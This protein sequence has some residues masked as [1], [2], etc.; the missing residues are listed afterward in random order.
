MASSKLFPM[1]KKRGLWW[2]YRKRVP[3]HLRGLFGGRREI[4][5]SLKT[6]DEGEA[7][8]RVL[9]IAHETE[10]ALQRAREKHRALV[11][12]P[13]AMAREWR[14][15]ILRV[16]QQDRLNRPRTE[17]SLEAEIDALESAVVDHREALQRGDTRPVL[18]VLRDVLERHKVTLTPAVERQL[19]HALLRERADALEI[20]LQRALGQ[21]RDEPVAPVSPLVSQVMESW[22]RERKPPSKT[23][24]EVR[25]IFG[26]FLA[27]CGGDQGIS[28]ITKDHVRAFRT[29]LLAGDAKT[30]KGTGA[31]APATIRKHLNLLGTVFR[32][33]VRTGLLDV[34]PVAGMA[35]VA[36]SKMQ[37]ASGKRQPFSLEAVRAFLSSPLYTGSVS[38]ARRAVPGP[39]IYKDAIWWTGLILFYSG[40]R[41]EE[42]GGLRG[43]DV[44]ER[45]G[46]MGFS[47]EVGEDRSLKTATAAR[48]VPLHPALVSAGLVDLAR[49]RGDGWLFPELK[50][51]RHG[52]RT[53]AVSKAFGRYLRA[54]KLDN[55]GKVVMHSARHTVVDRMRDAGVQEPI[56][57]AVVGHAHPGMTSRYGRGWDVKSLASAVASIQYP[58]MKLP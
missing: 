10:K 22:L 19:A 47:L 30:G 40:M 35:F 16:D 54:L 42:C 45:D 24:H 48:F 49:E 8:V 21:W 15:D 50:A 41:L 56:I 32:Y 5:V 17:E 7:R 55:G 38:K 29:R 1:L 44:R 18:S 4:V 25:A 23:A 57:A 34:S 12:D 53:S 2:S 6:Q 58:G 14:T 26:R 43:R 51:D 27:T 28:G 39:H 13:A 36:R 20:A 9:S 46:V 3:N 31:L 52:K 33:A 37:D 11:V